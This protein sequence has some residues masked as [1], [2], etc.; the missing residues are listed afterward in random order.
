MHEF[1]YLTFSAF[2]SQDKHITNARDELVFTVML[3]NQAA[4]LSVKKLLLS[5]IK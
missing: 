1:L 2:P 5:P 4:V 3:Q